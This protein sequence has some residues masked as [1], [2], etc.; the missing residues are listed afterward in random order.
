MLTNK[1]FLYW[2]VSLFLLYKES[3]FEI[4]NPL[5]VLYFL[6]F[7]SPSLSIKPTSSVLIIGTF[8]LLWNEVLPDSRIKNTFK[9]LQF[10]TLT[11]YN[12]AFRTI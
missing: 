11:V 10:C 5:F 4:T 3:D 1:L 6:L 7:P 12:K 8:T 2:S 9:L